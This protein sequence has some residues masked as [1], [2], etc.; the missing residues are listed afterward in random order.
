MRLGIRYRLLVPLALLLVGVVGASL[1]SARVAAL[2]A[3]ERVAGQVRSMSQTLQSATFPLTP[4]V[5][6]DMK[7]LSGAEFLL[8]GPDGS[9]QSTFPSPH[10]EVPMEQTFD[11]VGEYGLGPPVQVDGADYRCRR[12]VLKE[13]S[14]NAGAVVYIFYPE[15]LLEEAIADA[16]RPSFLGLLFGL[17]AVGLTFGI[18]QRL[19]GRIRALER[20]TRQIAGG[21]FSPMPLPRADD[22]LRDLTASVNDMAERLDRLQQAVQKTERVRLSAQVAGGLAHQLRN[23]VTGAKLAVQVYL[24]DHADDDTEAL[25]VTLRQLALMES[26]LRRFIDL[27]RPGPG[28]REVCDLATILGDVAELHR[29]R[30][31]HAGVELRWDPPAVDLRVDCDRDQLA[32]LFVNLVGNAVDAVG[33]GGEVAVLISRSDRSAI[34]E[35]R[36]TG[37]GPSAAVSA[38]LFEPFVTDKPEG[39]G[40][41][42]AV[43]RHAAAAHGGA[44]TWRRESGSTVFRVELPATGPGESPTGAG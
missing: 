13:P 15:S 40:L 21:D 18:A 39:I 3:E 1:W 11:G 24:G 8:I 38:R 44:I 33:S 4:R 41:G 10:V 20:R 28:K 5:L 22:E 25:R 29:P 19:V 27:G 6:E 2:R 26:N 32:D 34:V 35:V 23:S 43:A 36:D 9:R 37:P 7:G 16:E 30:C 17:V 31:K 14:R 42:L 12:L